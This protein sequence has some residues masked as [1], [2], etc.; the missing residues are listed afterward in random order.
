[1]IARQEIINRLKS[2]LKQNQF[3]FA[4]WLEGADAHKRVDKYS[5]I[6]IWLDVKD[7]KEDEVFKLIEIILTKLGK[8]DFAH[9]KDH[10]HPKIRQKFF[11]LE[12]TS[13]FLIID[14]CIQ[15][16]SRI[17]YYTKEY[18]DEK[19]KV[20]FDKTDGIITFKKLDKQKFMKENQERLKELEK[21]FI[22]FQ[23]WINKEI[24]RKK[25][26]EAFYNYQEKTLKPLVEILRL[27]F[28]PTKK[29]FYIN[30][31]YSD[32][33]KRYLTK[34]ENL[35]KINSLEDLKIKNKQANDLFFEIIKKF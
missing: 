9:E 6:D 10:P 1:M 5:D 17:F 26:L 31:I 2:E 28:E 35:Y 4:F 29:D 15:K 21:T 22:F 14:V 13:E 32:L 3:V 18:K 25:F 16:H 12:K 19:A 8:I 11:H 24:N 20:I 33:P 23:A 7:D 30:G 27:K 34:L